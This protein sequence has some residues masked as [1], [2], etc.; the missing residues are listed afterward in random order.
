MPG[1]KT[2]E[3]LIEEMERN[4][5]GK[6]LVER[7]EKSAK[8]IEKLTKEIK[9]LK[10]TGRVRLSP[11]TERD[12]RA[13]ESRI[14]RLKDD[15]EDLSRGM[16]QT[17]HDEEDEIAKV[18]IENKANT[19][20]KKT[21]IGKIKNIIK[22]KGDKELVDN[23]IIATKSVLDKDELSIRQVVS[24]DTKIQNRDKSKRYGIVLSDSSDSI[25]TMFDQ[26]NLRRSDSKT[27]VKS[28]ASDKT[29]G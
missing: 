14:N 3:Q 26:E 4:N 5:I 9:D 24:K 8:E 29:I 22:S 6:P 25:K 7:V 28:N 12:I 27:S 1:E 19:A 10:G 20:E 18:F 11:D 17:R 23:V 13:K 21:F 16:E 2:T 15:I